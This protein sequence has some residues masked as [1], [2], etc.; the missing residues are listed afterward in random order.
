[1]RKTKLGAYCSKPY[2][3]FGQIISEAQARAQNGEDC[4]QIIQDLV[5]GYSFGWQSANHMEIEAA[6]KYASRDSKQ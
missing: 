1:M 4:N 6:V 2:K 3:P 5:D